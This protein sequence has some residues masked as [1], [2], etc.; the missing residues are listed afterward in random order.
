MS[1]L[2]T[3]RAIDLISLSQNVTF[4]I[5][6]FSVV[7]VDLVAPT[8]A[9]C[10]EVFAIWREKFAAFELN[11]AMATGDSDPA[12]MADLSDLSAYQIAITTPEK[13]DV[14]TRRWKDHFSIA[15]AVRLVLID[16]VHL[17]GD[18]HRGATLEAIVSRIKLFPQ[19]QQIRFIS[20]SAW[21]PNIEDIAR[22]LGD[23]QSTDCVRIFK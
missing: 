15:N 21:L 13:F 7:W 22:W 19:S 23:N 9:L 17:V 8:K 10:S 3:V 11:V 6:N 4:S 16:E 18:T 2:F 20:V 1:E 14:M 12:E 5:F